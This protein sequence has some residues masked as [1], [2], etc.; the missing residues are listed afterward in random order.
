MKKKK[1]KKAIELYN[2]SGDREFFCSNCGTRRVSLSFDNIYK[3]ILK[4]C[5]VCGWADSLDESDLEEYL[6]EK[7]GEQDHE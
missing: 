7:E 3:N 1:I 4:E 2:N 5:S 6:L